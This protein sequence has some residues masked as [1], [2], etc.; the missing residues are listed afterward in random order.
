MAIFYPTQT[1][2]THCSHPGCERRLHC[3]EEWAI[4]LCALHADPD[5]PP[6]LPAAPD[7]DELLSR[8]DAILKEAEKPARAMNRDA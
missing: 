6:A 2:H 7:W 5:N 1:V 8:V 4:G 3:F